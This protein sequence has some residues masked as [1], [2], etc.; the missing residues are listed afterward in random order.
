MLSSPFDQ[1]PDA[2][3]RSLK[4]EKGTVLFRQGDKPRAFYFVERGSVRL[5]RHSKSGDEITIHRS[6]P[7]ETFAEASLFS[8][9]NHCDAIIES[10]AVIFQLDKLATLILM[11]TN[12]KFAKL[13][14]ARFAQQVQHYRRRIELLSVRSAELRVF[15]AVEEGWL[16]GDIKGFAS[17]IGLSHEATYRA[18]SQLVRKGRLSKVGRGKYCTIDLPVGGRITTVVNTSEPNT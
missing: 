9:A 1:L 6:F 11:E 3:R 12:L 2:S 8:D 18:L 4:A 14:T 5:V 15:M 10:D 13:L 7:G 16:F 17:Q